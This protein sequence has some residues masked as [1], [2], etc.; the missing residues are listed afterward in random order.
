M[1]TRKVWTCWCLFPYDLLFKL[2]NDS[3]QSIFDNARTQK[4]LSNYWWECE[5]V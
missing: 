1:C 3:L 2:T 4:W 5:K